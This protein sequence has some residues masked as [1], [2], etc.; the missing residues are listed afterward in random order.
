MLRSSF[1][2]TTN[3]IAKNQTRSVYFTAI[4]G[5]KFCGYQMPPH[6]VIFSQRFKKKLF[7]RITSPISIDNL[8][9]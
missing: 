5:D 1:L 7:R 6:L 2:P 9:A 3:K 8:I 4:E